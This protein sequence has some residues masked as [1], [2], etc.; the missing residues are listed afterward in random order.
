MDR[1]PGSPR[2]G[3]ELDTTERL[4]HS[5]ALEMQHVAVF[6]PCGFQGRVAVFLQTLGPALPGRPTWGLSLG[7]LKRGVCGSLTRDA[8][9]PGSR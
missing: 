1:E 3:K 6:P 5:S 8:I 4:T 2:G 9:L 7:Q